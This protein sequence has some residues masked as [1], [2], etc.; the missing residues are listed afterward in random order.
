MDAACLPA[1]A[2][3]VTFDLSVQQREA[4]LDRRIAAAMD[5][6]QYLQALLGVALVSIYLRTGCLPT[7]DV[8]TGPVVIDRKT[9]LSKRLSHS[10]HEAPLPQV[11]AQAVA[12][13]SSIRG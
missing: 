6:Q 13:G 7:T 5:C 11:R 12:R 4:L 2:N 10:E 8:L 1:L 3:H 9:L